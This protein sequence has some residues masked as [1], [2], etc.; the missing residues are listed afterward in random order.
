[1]KQ[2]NIIYSM[3]CR[4][5]H[6]RV[7]KDMKKYLDIRHAVAI[8]EMYKGEISI[9]DAAFECGD[10]YRGFYHKF[11]EYETCPPVD[12]RLIDLMK[13]YDME[14]LKMMDRHQSWKWKFED[15]MQVY[16]EHIRFWSYILDLYEISHAV[17]MNVP[18][19]VFDYVIYCLCKIKGIKTHVFF[20]VSV[21]WGRSVITSDFHLE[22]LRFREYYNEFMK[23]ENIAFSEE[24]LE[25]YKSFYDAGKEKNG[26]KGKRWWT[27][28][29][30]AKNN[31][32]MAYMDTRE[33]L[34]TRLAD[35]T[36]KAL[37][38]RI[39]DS[40]WAGILCRLYYIKNKRKTD[41]LWNYYESIAEKPVE[42]EKY[43]YYALH[44]QPE[45]TSCPEG[46]GI[47]ANQLIP[48]RILS[49]CLPKG[50]KLYIKEHPAQTHIGKH[51]SLYD[52]IKRLK[53]VR[54][55]TGDAD[56]YAL[57][58]GAAATATLTGT[59]AIESVTSEIP[60]ITFG[61]FYYNQ[62][63][64]V[65]HVRTCQE[66]KEALEHIISANNN[67]DQEKVKCFFQAIYEY[68]ESINVGYGNYDELENAKKMAVLLSRT[69]G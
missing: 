5:F 21:F 6:D 36:D 53:N 56:S 28:A 15:R 19:E 34:E 65:Y 11:K 46:G 50:Y 43:I 45:A 13:P 33:F 52:R 37:R 38:T 32:Y 22:H 25:K 44:Y 55:I 29:T 8:T 67:I 14:I 66:C 40:H 39:T 1:M 54:L 3:L 61:N 17:F 18:H 42:G 58:K 51:K 62:L 12:D 59:V 23:K 31:K 26:N 9:F 10:V 24:V 30:S 20:Q 4:D 16:Y 35:K 68:S 63:E 48:I 2:V 41:K 27:G 60:C 47:Y 64:G 7:V 69:I 57:L 49:F